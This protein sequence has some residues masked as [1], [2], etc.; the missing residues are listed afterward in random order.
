MS[1]EGDKLKLW[2]VDV[3]GTLMVVAEDAQAAQDVALASLSKAPEEMK[4]HARGVMAVDLNDESMSSFPWGGD[5]VR[6]VAQW[7][8]GKT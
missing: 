4:L 5:G 2:A 7:M 6:T 3:E 1:D 8:E